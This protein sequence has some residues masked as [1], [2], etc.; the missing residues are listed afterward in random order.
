MKLVTSKENNEVYEV[1]QPF[2]SVFW[3]IDDDENESW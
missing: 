3:S 2:F 1:I